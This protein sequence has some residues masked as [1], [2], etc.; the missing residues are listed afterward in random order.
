MADRYRNHNRKRE[1]EWSNAV[2]GRSIYTETRDK[3]Q[4]SV[5]MESWV[6]VRGLAWKY[7]SWRVWKP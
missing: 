1:I 3:R 7:M 2:G 5:Y 6:A 4:V